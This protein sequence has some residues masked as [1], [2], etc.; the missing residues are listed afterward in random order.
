MN[1]NEKRYSFQDF[2]KGSIFWMTLVI[3]TANHNF[4]CWNQ[5]LMYVIKS[6]IETQKTMSARGVVYCETFR[7]QNFKI[8][9]RLSKISKTFRIFFAILN[10]DVIKFKTDITKNQL[11]FFFIINRINLKFF[12][13]LA[14]S[15][16]EKFVK[17]V[18]NLK[19]NCLKLLMKLI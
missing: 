18:Q 1:L 17:E 5:K 11:H 7:R 16:L 6:F 14:I 12:N 8:L 4:F 10:L 9:K 13:L 15:F 2:I 19:K 3:I